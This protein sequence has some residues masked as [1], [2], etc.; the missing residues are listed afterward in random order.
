MNKKNDWIEKVPKQN[1]MQI[2]RVDEICTESENQ[3]ILN[4]PSKNK[5]SK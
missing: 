4:N 5:K 1:K 2:I 3:N